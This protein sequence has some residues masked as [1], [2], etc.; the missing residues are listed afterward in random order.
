MAAD[1]IGR[2]CKVVGAAL[3]HVSCVHIT[4][5]DIATQVIDIACTPDCCV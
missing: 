2:R 1:E 5:T 4:D 3:R